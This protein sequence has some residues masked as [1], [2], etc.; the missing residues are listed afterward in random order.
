M[1]KTV[2]DIKTWLDTPLSRKC[3][4]A[5]VGYYSGDPTT[6]AYSSGFEQ[7]MYL[8]TM[9][10][11]N[12]N[13]EYLPILLGG[14]SFSESLSTDL[15]ISVSYGTIELENTGGSYDYFLTYIWKRRPIKIYLGDISWAKTDFV[16]IFDGLVDNL[17]TS[18]ES[19]LQITLL[20]RLEQLNDV[21]NT[22]TIKDLSGS[23]TAKTTGETD[24][25][26]PLLFGEVFNLSPIL[27]DSG[28]N[29]DTGPWTATIKGFT[30]TTG[31]NI[32]DAISA[33]NGV[34]SI[35][36]GGSYV[37]ASVVSKSIVTFTATGGTRPLPGT[38]TS[39]IVAGSA[40]SGTFTVD[41]WIKGTGGPVYKISD[42][43]LDEIVE[44]RDKAAP[45]T[46]NS[47]R[48]TS[49]EFMLVNSVFGAVTCTA[50]STTSINCTVPLIIKDI[51]KN[52]GNNKLVDSE[53][54]LSSISSA[55]ANYKVGIYITDRVNTLDICNQLAAS[56]SC[57]LYYSPLT[58]DNSGYT[59]N[60]KLKLI[61]LKKPVL[62]AGLTELN[63]SLML[64]GTLQIS[65]SFPI[66]PS[67][68]LAYCKNYTQQ[69]QDLALALN[70]KHG[71][72]YKDEYWFIEKKPS[73]ASGSAGAYDTFTSAYKDTGTVQEEITH[74]LVTSEAEQ[75]AASRLELWSTP[76]QL[77]TATYLPHLLF[78][79]LG[80]TVKLTS[81]RFNLAAGVAGLVYSINR[82]WL[83]GFVEIGVL[84]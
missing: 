30:D 37:I 61:E 63:D 7:T 59:S 55:R 17:T 2:Q 72:V 80:D 70:T 31:I 33:T 83:T 60:G 39:L 14:L 40:K 8:S 42:S 66:K 53:L 36:T 25:L 16:L 48:V 45:I 82:D 35:G 52:Y 79:Q 62:A 15:S 41:S 69:S 3:L 73:A 26:L 21:L 58:I 54:D 44:V 20:N 77:I 19:R 18:G 23:Y 51:V 74:L 38:I 32:G 27:V 6:A 50:R 84:V 9:A 65:E 71:N 81:N 10:Y 64:E 76:R 22:R 57:S 46:V 67:I 75:E 12:S 29:Y 4:L 78:V 5:D 68:K 24:K 11:N 34:G 49:G 1:P 56:I 28:I 43:S 13:Q 47:S